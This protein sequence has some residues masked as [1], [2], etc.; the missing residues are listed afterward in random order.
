MVHHAKARV[1]LEPVNRLDFEPLRPIGHDALE[2]MD[3]GVDCI[4]RDVA[5]Q[6]AERVARRLDSENAT[7]DE[8][9]G[10]Q[11]GIEPNVRTNVDHVALWIEQFE[12]FAGQDR[13][14]FT[15]LDNAPEQMAPRGKREDPLE[16]RNVKYWVLGKQF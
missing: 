4:E 15:V 11:Y 2:H 3:L 14:V 7:A 9:L 12:A 6:P 10:Q 13:L 5:S 16:L 8:V 1:F